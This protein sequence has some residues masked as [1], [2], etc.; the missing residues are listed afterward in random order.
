[1]KVFDKV[2]LKEDVG[3]WKYGTVGKIVFIP[4]ESDLYVVEILDEIHNTVCV[5]ILNKYD[6]EIFI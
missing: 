2:F 6:L 4:K 5:E 3:K 1:M